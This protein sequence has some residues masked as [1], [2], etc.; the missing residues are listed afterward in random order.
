MKYFD[1]TEQKFC[2]I[3]RQLKE[4]DELK[5]EVDDLIRK[6]ITEGHDFLSGYGMS[7]DHECAV[8][9]LLELLTH[10]K[11][12]WISWWCWEQDYGEGS[13]TNVYYKNG[14]ICDVSTPELLYAFLLQEYNEN[15]NDE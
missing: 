10:D 6:H 13:D 1:I 12:E 8:V 9:D 5:C 11:G 3:L 7:I 15:D 14:D 2:D 4:A